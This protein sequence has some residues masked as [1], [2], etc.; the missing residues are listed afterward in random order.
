MIIRPIEIAKQLNISTSLLRHYEK[1]CY[2]PY[3]REV[4]VVIAFIQKKAC[5]ISG[6]SGR[7]RSL[8]AIM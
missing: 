3:L 2:F 7:Q 5:I 4:A 1:N 6:R 8:M